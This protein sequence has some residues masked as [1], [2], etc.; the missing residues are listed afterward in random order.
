[1]PFLP[2]IA[3][4]KQTN[5]FHLEGNL[6]AVL[7]KNKAWVETLSS[8]ISHLDEEEQKILCRVKL[9]RDVVMQLLMQLS[10]SVRHKKKKLRSVERYPTMELRNNFWREKTWSESWLF[11]S[12]AQCAMRCIFF[13]TSVLNNKL[14]ALGRAAHGLVMLMKNQGRGQS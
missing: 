9:S 1:M 13:S 2:P 7:G 6:S 12:S 3:S 8:H 4:N 10:S 5:I 11:F 14:T